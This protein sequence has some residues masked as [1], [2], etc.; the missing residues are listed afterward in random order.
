MAHCG[1]LRG[2]SRSYWQRGGLNWPLRCLGR[3][4]FLSKLGFFG[5]ETGK[6]WSKLGSVYGEDA[7]EFSKWFVD[8]L[9]EETASCDVVIGGLGCPLLLLC[10]VCRS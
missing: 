10:L 6:F 2:L 1:D 5:F 4:A 3:H 9:G 7:V 8:V